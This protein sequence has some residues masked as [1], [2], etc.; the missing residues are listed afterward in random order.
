[1][2]QHIWAFHIIQ[3]PLKRLTG[4]ASCYG[5]GFVVRRSAI[6][7]IGGL[8]LVDVG[9]DILLGSILR[10]AGWKISFVNDQVAFGLV[11]KTY[12]AYVKQRMRWVSASGRNGLEATESLLIPI[13]ER[14]NDVNV[15]LLSFLHTGS[16]FAEASNGR[17]ETSPDV[18]DRFGLQ[19]YTHDSVPG[20]LT[21]GGVVCTD[22]VALVTC[23]ELLFV[24]GQALILRA[25]LHIVDQQSS[26]ILQSGHQEE[27]KSILD[28]SV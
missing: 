12:A 28:Q 11:P 25:I 10:D 21:T 26:L 22:Y 8:P 17:T 20:R 16:S 5:S 1:M 2:G 19:Q 14:R 15:A 7:D 24:L 23:S 27:H 4:A 13:E 9:E 18:E 6:H 3:E